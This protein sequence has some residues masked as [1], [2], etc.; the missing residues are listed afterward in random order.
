MRDGAFRKP[1]NFI[2]GS[3]SRSTKNKP[4]RVAWL[5]FMETAGVEPA[6]ENLFIQLSP[7]AD[8]LLNF[9]YMPPAVR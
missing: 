7:G 5:F 4:R 2:A 3:P 8:R 1:M 9:L 6:S